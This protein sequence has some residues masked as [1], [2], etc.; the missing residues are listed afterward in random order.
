MQELP[1]NRVLKDHL[2]KCIRKTTHS[3]NL[4]AYIC[5]AIFGVALIAALFGLI[6][7]TA[8]TSAG[9]WFAVFLTLLPVAGSYGVYW[10]S[11]R[12]K[13]K[14]HHIFF[15]DPHAV[16]RIEAKTIIH[17]PFITYMFHF[18]AP[19]PVKMVGINVP[20]E[21]IFS[22]LQKMLPAHFSNAK[23]DKAS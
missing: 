23:Y 21:A 17:L 6:N 5:G 1:M 13:K 8:E 10:H 15:V 11:Q 18:Y 19:A 9:M 2:D 12:I 14:L 3:L 16:N 4:I 7:A 20:S 22:D